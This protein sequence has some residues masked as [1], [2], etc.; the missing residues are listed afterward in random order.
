MR[1]VRVRSSA[2]PPPSSRI[3]IH[4]A[5]IRIIRRD[6][7]PVCGGAVS[8][9]V[10]SS[11]AA[12]G[13]AGT[14]GATAR[15]SV[16]AAGLVGVVEAVAKSTDGSDHVGTQL[17]A[18]AGDEDLDGVGIAVEILVVDVFDQLGAADHLALVMHQVAEQ[19][20]L[21]RG[22]LD[23]LAGPRD[24]ARAGVE[25]HVAGYQLGRGMAARA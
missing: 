18:D 7:L 6:R 17:L 20:V 14:A 1:A 3:E 9:A 4:P 16:S 8:E 25:P 21:L 5:A 11:P 10:G 19:L 23:R 15:V 24:A 22:Q 2:M 12:A 13:G